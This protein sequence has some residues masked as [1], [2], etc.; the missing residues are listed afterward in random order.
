VA[1]QVGPG[2]YVPNRGRGTGQELYSRT[3]LKNLSAPYHMGIEA[4]NPQ[5]N[6]SRDRLISETAKFAL[7]EEPHERRTVAS[8]PRARSA[9]LACSQEGAT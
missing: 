2:L 1:A 6:F 3:M 5:W 4:T 8:S 9:Q 7:E